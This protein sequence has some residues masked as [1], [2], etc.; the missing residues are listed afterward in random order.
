[1]ANIVDAIRSLFSKDETPVERVRRLEAIV[2]K[3]EA[4]IH[5]K[6]LKLEELQSKITAADAREYITGSTEGGLK[7]LELEL[8][9]LERKL[10]TAKV[11]ASVTEKELEAAR[12]AVR[13]A[14]IASLAAEARKLNDIRR[15][16]YERGFAMLIAAAHEFSHAGGWTM[17]QACMPPF[18]RE[19]FRGFTDGLAADFPA[20]AR[21]N[22]IE[23]QLGKLGVPHPETIA[24]T[25]IL[26]R[27]VD[28]LGDKDMALNIR[29]HLDALGDRFAYT[30]PISP[31]QL[32][33]PVLDE[34]D[35]QYVNI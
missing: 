16:R 20:Q 23:Q 24:E 5:D 31:R 28:P 12:A 25:A 9:K 27:P 32:H 1:M 22:E 29:K 11:V 18:L 4:D 2:A 17:A 13:D 3:A 19:R 14:E 15:D 10:K 26:V 33:R 21:L 7:G 6:G 8:A 34:I 30:G 35:A